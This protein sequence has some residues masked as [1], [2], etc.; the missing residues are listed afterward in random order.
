MKVAKRLLQITGIVLILLVAGVFIYLK[1]LSPST[2]PS[3]RDEAGKVPEKS[4]A[5]MGYVNLGGVKQF[6]L[7]RGRSTENPVLLWLHGGPG[8]PELP[9]CRKFN[10]KLE[11]HYTVVYWDQRGAG[12]SADKEIP[13][14]SYTVE[15]LVEDT[16]ELTLYLKNKLQKEKIFLLGHS[17]GSMLGILTASKYPEDYYAYVGTGQMGNQPESDSLSYCF[18]YEKAEAAND[19][20]ALSKLKSIGNYTAK[21][22]EKTG[23]MNWLAVQ[24]PY[25]TG[26][27]GSTADPA[28][29]VAIFLEPI[30]YCREYSIRDKYRMMKSNT[31]SGF[32][33]TPFRNLIHAA[34]GTDLTRTDTLDVPLF[35]L[36]GQKDYLTNYAVAREYFDRLTA[37]EKE[38]IT[39][40]NSGHFPHF[41]EADKFNAFMID[42]VLSE[43]DAF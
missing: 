42:R 28:A 39:F 21:N 36:Q 43:A 22:L 19:T 40:D 24:R 9:M 6:I 33:N 10:S 23:F 34:L 37:P 38:F 29:S 15:R 3:F 27:G 11:D 31:E 32:I 18:V 26:Y 7:I 2:T 25:V 4:I 14:E 1:I 30:L 5:M 13:I 35:F 17:W 16:H 12:K 20:A 8:S 41:E